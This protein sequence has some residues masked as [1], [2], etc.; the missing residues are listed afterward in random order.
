M[1]H[2]VVKSQMVSFCVM[3]SEEVT[4]VEPIKAMCREIKA[5]AKGGDVKSMKNPWRD[6]GLYPI[7]YID[8]NLYFMSNK[9]RAQLNV[10]WGNDTMFFVRTDNPLSAAKAIDLSYKPSTKVLKLSGERYKEIYTGQLG[11]ILQ[12]ETDGLI[13]EFIAYAKQSGCHLVISYQDEHLK[14]IM[15]MIITLQTIQH[16]VKQIGSDFDIEFR[17]EAYRDDKGNANKICTNLPSSELRDDWLTRLTK[18]W[19]DDLEHDYN[20]CGNLIPVVSLPKRTLTHWRVLS[21]TCGDKQLAIYPDGGFINEW[22]IARQPNGERFEVST[23]THDAKIYLYRNKDI[24]FDVA[25]EK[26]TLTNV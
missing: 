25:I 18:A 4:M 10:Q 9:D 7:A 24:K 19:I 5:W 22:N 11:E 20:I 23:I 6:N 26:I 1:N 2:F 14:S 13:D 17:I 15:G 12:S 8:G 16:I 21:I 3:E